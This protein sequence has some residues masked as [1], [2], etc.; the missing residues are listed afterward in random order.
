M[1]QPDERSRPGWSYVVH[2][3]VHASLSATFPSDE[4]Q[5][6]TSWSLGDSVGLDLSV[7]EVLDVAWIVMKGDVNNVAV[8]ANASLVPTGP[9]TGALRTRSEA[10][11]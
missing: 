8:A 11:P 4:G 3:V 7:G 9:A 2:V 10:L 1:C 5:A 6:S